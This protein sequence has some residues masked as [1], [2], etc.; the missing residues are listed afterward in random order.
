MLGRCPAI[1]ISQF[2]H[3]AA[4]LDL[5]TLAPSNLIEQPANQRGLRQKRSN[6]RKNLPTILFPGTRTAKIN[7][8]SRWQ[9]IRADAPALHFPPV[10]LRRCES[11]GLYVEVTRSL[12]AKHA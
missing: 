3:R 10:K 1:H 6:N 12:A 8:A 5:S 11:N 2:G 4:R 9:A 7:L